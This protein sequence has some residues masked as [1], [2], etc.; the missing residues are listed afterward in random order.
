[1][2]PH[3]HVS[4]WLALA[5]ATYFAWK[6]FAPIQL[7]MAW[8]VLIALNA[9]AFLL[10]GIDKTAANMGATRVPEKLLYLASF[11][12]GS[13]GALV[14]MNLFRHKTRKFS[15]QMVMALL[16]LVQVGLVW[17]WVDPALH[18]WK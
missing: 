12:G 17:L 10:F 4:R 8:E 9:S 13:F 7:A 3:A 18:F 14:A 16:V 15:F 2:N 1:M 6:Q 5:A 11:L